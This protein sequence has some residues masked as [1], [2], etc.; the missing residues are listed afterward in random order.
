MRFHL[1]LWLK[2]SR[3]LHI[4]QIMTHNSTLASMP[5]DMFSKFK[6][7]TTHD[8]FQFHLVAN[9]RL[10]KPCL[11]AASG[12][13][14]S[15]CCE[16]MFVGIVQDESTR[17]R[18]SQSTWWTRQNCPFVLIIETLFYIVPSK[19]S[20]PQVLVPPLLRKSSRQTLA[21]HR[22]SHILQK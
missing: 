9:A 5:S 21:G 8:L 22:N 16:Y 7:S 3:P 14:V 19:P 6:K 4:M 18:D 13:I 12:P 10:P 20:T 11:T 2:S 1:E 17:E 15:V